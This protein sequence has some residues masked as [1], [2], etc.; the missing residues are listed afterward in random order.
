MRVILGGTFDPV[1]V[2]HL[3]MA[4]ELIS[5]LGVDCIYLMP[6][7]QAVHKGV[8]ASSQ[9]RLI[10]VRLALKDDPC[11]ILVDREIRRA[12]PSYTIQSRLEIREEG[13]SEPVCR[14]LGTDA[15]EGFAT[16]KRVTE[17]SSLTHIVVMQRPG[18]ETEPDLSAFESLGFAEAT[19]V[20][21]MKQQPAGK[22]F[23][24]SLSALDIS[25]TYI[26]DCIKKHL[27]VRYLVTDE[28]FHY[29][30]DNGL[31]L[32]ESERKS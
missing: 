1:H 24:V 21:D 2:G 17:F 8:G 7:Y 20:D 25:S 22:I 6:C 23:K 9:H 31:Y 32:A 29:I 13:A 18:S 16:W 15:A 30:C 19:C 5:T 14:V 28:V 10:M 4:T 3:R 11:L 12:M 27:S 26:R